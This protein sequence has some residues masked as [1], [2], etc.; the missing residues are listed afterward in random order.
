[1]RVNS[2]AI[3]LILSVIYLIVFFYVAN[4]KGN[5]FSQ[6]LFGFCV[7]G[8]PLPNMAHGCNA[9]LLNSHVASFFIDS[10][11][12]LYVWLL[13]LRCREK[14]PSS[15]RNLTVTR[16]FLA[17]GTIMLCHGLLHL[18]LFLAIDCYIPQAKIS[19]LLNAFGFLLFTSFTF[20][21]TL[22]L[23]G[24]GFAAKR[25]WGTLIWYSAGFTALVLTMTIRTGVEWILPSLFAISHPLASYVGLYAEAP[26]L[27]QNVGWLFLM[28]TVMGILEL[29][30]CPNLFRPLGGH[31]W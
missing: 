1:M 3:C 23:L 9:G 21:L 19:K 15:F 8:S 18:F 25:G 26:Q 20:G 28:A 13:F 6:H 12:V 22:L 4:Q 17:I 5:E 31:V 11:I 30:F 29:S 16:Y 14:A 10:F 27:T 7:W 2:W 24:I